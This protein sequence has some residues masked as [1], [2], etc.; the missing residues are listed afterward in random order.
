MT[1]RVGIVTNLYPWSGGPTLGTFVKDLVVHL[2]LAG[3]DVTLVNHR[4]NFAAMSLE[5]SIRSPRLDILDAQFIA[6]AGI[7]TAFSPH[8][9]PYVVTVHRWDI[10]EFPYRY[11][12]ARMATLTALRNAAGIIA[13]GRT[14][15]SEVSKFTSPGSRVEVIPNAVDVLR[16]RPDLG[17]EQLKKSLGIPKDHKVVLSVGHLIPRK[18][19]EYLIR[20]TARILKRNKA[21]SLVI[22]G[23]GP[24]HDRLEHLTRELGISNNVKLCGAVADEML[25]VYYAMSDIFAMPSIS[26]GHCVAIL[27][28]MAS[29]KSIVASNIPA[30]AE[31]VVQGSNGFLVP[32]K[33]SEALVDPILLLLNDDDL[34]E[35]FGRYSRTRAKD[36]FSWR[37]RTERLLDFYNSI[38]ASA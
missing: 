3:V 22:A 18:G 8:F 37:R 1:L 25:P 11:P 2:R 15:L 17:F 23:E 4:I 20:A 19:H 34:R 29:G 6:P 9:A 38:L 10:L 30:N 14:I 5:C 26:E 12:L 35:R 36:E 27:E 31:S 32:T 21:C 7:I 16:F 33:S 13:V 24:M 28:A